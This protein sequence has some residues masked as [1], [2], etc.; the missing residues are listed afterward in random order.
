MLID[1]GDARRTGPLGDN[2]LLLDKCANRPFKRLFIN[3]Q[4]IINIFCH[5][6]LGDCAR[7]FYRYTFGQRFAATRNVLTGDR[8]LHRRIK[9]GL[10]ADNLYIGAHVAGDCGYTADQPATADWHQQNIQIILIAQHFQA[11]SALTGHHKFIVI[12]VDQ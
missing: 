8:L 5:N 9:C 6:R 4:N 12:R 3:Q 2:A 11:G 7:F 10:Y 1:G